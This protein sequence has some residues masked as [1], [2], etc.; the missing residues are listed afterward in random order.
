MER[1]GREVSWRRA[2]ASI[3]L[4]LLV[5]LT[6]LSL[7]LSLSGNVIRVKPTTAD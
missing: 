7:S 2:A 5:L 1:Q 4:V 3:Q 6:S